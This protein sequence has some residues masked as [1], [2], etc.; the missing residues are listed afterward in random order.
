MLS[1]PHRRR[2]LEAAVLEIPS[3]SLTPQSLQSQRRSPTVHQPPSPI[4]PSL[5][6]SSPSYHVSRP[7]S[8]HLSSAH[9]GP[10][11]RE[12]RPKRRR[13]RRRKRRQCGS[14]GR[15][16]KHLVIEDDRVWYAPYI[17]YTQAVK[18]S[19]YASHIYLLYIPWNAIISQI[20]R[21]HAYK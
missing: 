1:L 7:S 9:L 19:F 13:K 4:Q 5:V 12:R 20:D 21:M 6:Q 16:S 10:V 15:N 14:R 18:S 17:H 11:R 3:R 8:D 2:N